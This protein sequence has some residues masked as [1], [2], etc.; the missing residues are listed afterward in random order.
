[1][2]KVD[3]HD[4]AGELESFMDQFSAFY[5]KETGKV[6]II[7]SDAIDPALDGKDEYIGITDMDLDEVREI[8]NNE[9]RY[10]P[11]PDQFDIHEYKIM[12]DFCFTLEDE[13]LC[14]DF[15][16]AIKGSGAFRR[17]KNKLTRHNL[18]ER[19]YSYKHEA[20]VKI[21]IE[22]CEEHGFEYER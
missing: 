20:Y 7:P 17:F 22:W 15:L 1:M 13:N 10:I 18:R 9:T 3:V 19:W 14:A 2:N 5:D 16:N 12:E 21:V 8:L 11:L 6:V 4:V